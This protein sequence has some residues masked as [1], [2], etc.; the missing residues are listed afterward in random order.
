MNDDLTDKLPLHFFLS[1]A[2]ESTREV[3]V[4]RADDRAKRPISNQCYVNQIHPTK[5]LC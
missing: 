4:G 5:L 1:D 2:I 3:S